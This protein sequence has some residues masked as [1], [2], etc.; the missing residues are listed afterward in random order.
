[1][2]RFFLE[3]SLAE[4]PS[5]IQLSEEE[6][7]HACRVLRLGRNDT[8]ILVDGMG[9]FAEAII[10]EDHPKR[11]LC[12]VQRVQEGLDRKPE[13]HLA[14]APPKNISR[15]EWLLEKATEIGLGSITPL[16]T[17]HSERQHLKPER[18]KKVLISAMKQSQ[19]SWLPQLHPLTHFSAFI[20]TSLPSLRYLA[21]LNKDSHPLS[22]VHKTSAPACVLIGPEGDFSL[23]EYLDA[24]RAG[25]QA[26]SLGQARLRTE[27]AALYACTALN[28]I[29]ESLINE[30]R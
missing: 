6:S 28:F 10:L 29:N 20:A 18:L 14:V 13:I 12:Q 5:Q 24:I 23:E 15:F 2:H 1:M 4:A 8:L 22:M 26:V 25:F 17:T 16:H 27:T 21:Y 19:R 30:K 7:H 11:T 3:N 9:H